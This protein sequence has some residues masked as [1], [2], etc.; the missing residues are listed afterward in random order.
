M[1]FD[2][3]KEYKNFYAPK[4]EPELVDIPEMKFIAVEGNG[5]PRKGEPAKMRTIIRHPV[6]RKTTGE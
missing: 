6:S 4:L 3:K 5:D 1:A 2:Y